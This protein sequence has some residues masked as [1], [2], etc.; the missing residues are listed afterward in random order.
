MLIK[1][2]FLS[3]FIFF[4][5]ISSSFSQERKAENNKKNYFYIAPFDFFFNTLKLGYERKMK[6][7]NSFFLAGG[8]KLS[9]K[10]T[11]INRIGGNVEIQYRINLFYNKETVNDISIL[12]NYS[13]FSYFAP[14]FQYRYEEIS[15]NFYK[16]SYKSDYTT[17]T[18]VNS[19]FGGA[20][21]G[22]RF[23]GIENRFSFN[24]FAGGGLK[25]SELIGEKKYTDFFDVGYT[26][27]A[28]KLDFQIG[29]AF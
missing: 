27:F 15:D 1:K 2:I 22:L 3:F 20:G 28:P 29:V 21:L 12:K 11:L 6:N 14:Y 7:Y 23:T 5:F 13:L 4:I 16:N 19:Y 9:E 26:G 10:E 8:F 25:Y 17:T 18:I 24:L